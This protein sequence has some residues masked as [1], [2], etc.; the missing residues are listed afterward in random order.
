ML[1]P[2]VDH[3]R[4]RPP[5]RAQPTYFG[6][7]PAPSGTYAAG[8]RGA[9]GGGYATGG[10]SGYAAGSGAGGDMFDLPSLSFMD[11]GARIK[12]MRHVQ[13]SV[14]RRGLH[15]R[16]AYDGI[17]SGCLDGACAGSQQQ[18]QHWR[19]APAALQSCVPCMLSSMHESS[20]PCCS[21]APK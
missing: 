15:A 3:C 17:A 18:L 7:P 1:V 9:Y 12:V 4:G 8:G 6:Q 19:R 2:P 21:S 10:G 13:A 11:T 5:A 14:D 16:G 20:C